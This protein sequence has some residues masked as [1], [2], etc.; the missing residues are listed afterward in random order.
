MKFKI[1]ENFP[2]G[3]KQIL[4]GCSHDCHTVYDEG[5]A[6]GS[7]DRLIEICLSEERHLIT[8]DLDFADIVAYPP[9]GYHGIIVFRLSRQQPPYVLKRFAEV[10]PTFESMELPGHLVVIDDSRIRYR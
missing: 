2:V 9:E 8:M 4:I 3:A 7:D 1:D 10:L 5:I 6:G